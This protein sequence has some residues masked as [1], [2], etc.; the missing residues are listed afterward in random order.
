MPT[1]L[2]LIEAYCAADEHDYD[3]ASARAA[4]DPLLADDSLG[5]V[6]MLGGE[7]A[8]GYAVITWGHSIESGGREAL[9][10]EIFVNETGNGIGGAAMPEILAAARAA[11]ARRIFLETES[12]NV[13]ARRFYER[14]GF[15]TEDSVWMSRDL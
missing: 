3:A 5:Q 9:L 1:L 6:W 14:H 12:R 2:A 7:P 10:D 15:V 11:G 8:I 13:D 4:L